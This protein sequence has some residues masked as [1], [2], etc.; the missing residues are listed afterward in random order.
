MGTIGYQIYL[1]DNYSDT[2]TDLGFTTE[3]SFSYPASYS[4]DEYTFI[5]KSAYSIFK[6]NMSSGLEIA[7]QSSYDT[8]IGDL[9]GF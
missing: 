5:V 1:K 6:D 7:S 3:T 9:S 4:G 2:L 8:N